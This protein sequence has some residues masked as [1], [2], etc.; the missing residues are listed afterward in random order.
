[1]QISETWY[2]EIESTLLTT[3]EYKLVEKANAPFPNLTCTTSSEN[4]SVDGI[5]TFP[6]L[7]IHLLPLVEVGMDLTNES[8]NAVRATLEL[9][10]FSN[11]SEAECRKIMTRGLQEMKL[12]HFNVTSF[13]DYQTSNKRYFAIARCTRIIAGGDSEIVP[14][15]EEGTE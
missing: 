3:L 10:V 14:R 6:T 2:S 8:V 1:M 13:P 7:Y 4:D 9:Q 12:L 5:A 11:R 15:L